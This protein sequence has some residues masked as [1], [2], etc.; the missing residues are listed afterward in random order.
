[1]SGTSAFYGFVYAPNSQITI[2]GNAGYYGGAMGRSLVMNNNGG[3][4]ADE[5][6]PPVQEVPSQPI[7]VQ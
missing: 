3:V 7:L 1:V 4:H 2:T 6:L 5:S